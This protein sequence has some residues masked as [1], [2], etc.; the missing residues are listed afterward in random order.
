MFGKFEIH[1]DAA[2]AR[3]NAQVPIARPAEQAAPQNNNILHWLADAAV[4][5][6]EVASGHKS[7]IAGANGQH[8]HQD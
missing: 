4:T 5:A 1:V 6:L 2:L 8:E 3:E 7:T